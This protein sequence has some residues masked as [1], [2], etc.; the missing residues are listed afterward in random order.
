MNQQQMKRI[1]KL[2]EITKL[3]TLR[4]KL[5]LVSSQEKTEEEGAQADESANMAL[6]RA[7]LLRAKATVKTW[8][9]SLYFLY[10]PQWERYALPNLVKENREQV[11]Q[12]VTDLEIPIIDVHT[13]FQ[14]HGDPLSLF[15]FRRSGHYNTEG[16]R[17]VADTVLQRLSQ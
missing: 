11:L 10:V 17:L 15:P 5:G 7:L 9:G 6:F 3:S 1:E 8:G 13:A 4:P 2:V 14:S 16:N 12:M